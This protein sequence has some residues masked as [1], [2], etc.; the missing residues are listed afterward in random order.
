DQLHR[1]KNSSSISYNNPANS[2]DNANR[3]ATSY[4]Y[5]RNGNI[6]NLTRKNE[7]GEFDNLNYLYNMLPE[8]LD[9]NKLR[10]VLDGSTISLSDNSDFQTQMDNNYEYDEIGNLTADESEHID[11]IKWNIQGKVTDVIFRQDLVDSGEKKNIHYTYDG[12]GN[13]LSKSVQGGYII[14]T[15]Y[16][17]RDA[18]GN[19]M[20]TYD[21]NKISVRTPSGSGILTQLKQSEI[22]IYGSSRIGIDKPIDR[23]FP[24]RTQSTQRKSSDY[25]GSLVLREILYDS[26]ATPNSPYSTEI[27]KGEFVLLYNQNSQLTLDLGGLRLSHSVTGDGIIFPDGMILEPGRF[28]MVAYGSPTDKQEVLR[29]AGMEE[30]YQKLSDTGIPE[31]QWFWHTQMPLP[32]TG[33]SIRIGEGYIGNDP[34]VK[35]AYILIDALEYAREGSFANNSYFDTSIYGTNNVIVRDRVN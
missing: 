16:Y 29:L 24:N 14:N 26:P 11:K 19:V 22:P 6:K 10:G 25:I 18:S 35:Y 5:D 13:R 7:N 12:M 33:G 27:H 9:N 23:V 34:T 4:T 20:S 1:I 2:W 31:P 17:A 15:T 30:F 8:G 21:C 3:Y 28:L 32:D